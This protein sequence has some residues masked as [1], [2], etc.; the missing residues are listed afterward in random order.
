MFSWREHFSSFQIK[1]QKKEEEA[2]RWR[3]VISLLRLKEQLASKSA[4]NT[5]QGTETLEENRL[6]LWNPIIQ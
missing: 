3:Q 6:V 2:A 4:E 1:S 5:D